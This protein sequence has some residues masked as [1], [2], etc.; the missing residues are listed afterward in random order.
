MEADKVAQFDFDWRH[1][2]ITYCFGQLWAG[3]QKD[4]KKKYFYTMTPLAS[5]CHPVGP[6]QACP[7]KG[8]ARLLVIIAWQH[9]TPS[10]SCHVKNGVKCA[11]MLDVKN[12]QSCPVLFELV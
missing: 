3:C 5:R 7:Q 4:K 6:D 1:P 11:V 12:Q 2:Q 9:S 10:T 8:R